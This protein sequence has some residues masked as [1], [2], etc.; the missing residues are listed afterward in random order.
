LEGD[1]IYSGAGGKGGALTLAD[2]KS[3]FLYAALAGSR[4]SGDVLDAFKRAIW[5][6]PVNSITLDNGSGFARHREIAGRHNTD[7]YF[8]DH[9]LAMAERHERE[10]ERTYPLLLF[11]GHGFQDSYERGFGTRRFFDK[12]SPA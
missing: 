12:Q 5:D 1:T 6:T 10:H 11:E 7:V 8:A 3:K 4:D 2:K 9:P